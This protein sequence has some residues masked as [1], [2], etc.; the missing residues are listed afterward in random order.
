MSTGLRKV[1]LEPHLHRGR[2]KNRKRMVRERGGREREKAESGRFTDGW[3]VMSHRPVILKLPF[4]ILT[5][6]VVTRKE[7]R[8]H[9]MIVEATTCLLGASCPM[10]SRSLTWS[11]KGQ[12]ERGGEGGGDETVESL[13]IGGS[14]VLRSGFFRSP[15]RSQCV[16]LVIG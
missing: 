9:T 13:I 6:S 7:V 1:L 15:T 12:G 16:G 8:G 14:K 4:N 3:G 2:E 11:T 5:A 10:R